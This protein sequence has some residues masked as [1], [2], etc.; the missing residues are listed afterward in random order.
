MS[1]FAREPQVVDPV[2]LTFDERGR[3]YVVEMRDYPLGIGPDHR[4]GGAIRLLEDTDHDGRVDRSTVFAENLSFPTSILACRGGVLVAAPPEIL[5]LQDLDGDG[6][7]D[8]R[9]V[10]LKGF[11]LGVTDSNLSGLR[12]GLDNRVHAVNGGNGGVV[13]SAKSPG[14]PLDLR[15]SDFSFTFD[16]RDLRRTFPTSGGFGLVFDDW[17]HR[18]STYNINHIQQQVLAARYLDAAAG[19]F[20]VEGTA[21]ISDHGDMARIFPVSVAATRVNHPEQAGYFS[22]AGGV[23]FIS[24]PGYRGDLAGSVTVC[25]VVGNLVH[26]DVLSEDGPVFKASRSPGETAREFFASRDPACRPVGL[27]PGPDGALYLIDMQRDVIEHPDYIPQKVKDKLNLR[28]GEDRGRIYRITPKGGLPTPAVDLG[29]LPTSELTKRLGDPRPWWR[30]QAQRLIVERADVRVERRLRDLARHS[31]EPLARL[32]AYWTLAG[33]NRFSQDDLVAILGERHPGLLEN[34]LLLAEEFPSF[35]GE[36]GRLIVRAMDHEHPRVRLQAALTA[37]LLAAWGPETREA[38]ARVWVR[39]F[40]WRWSR[41]AVLAAWRSDAMDLLNRSLASAELASRPPAVL[42]GG[43]RELAMVAAK[44]WGSVDSER[45]KRTLELLAASSL[46][47]SV[48]A[49][50]LNGLAERDPVDAKER[51]ITGGFRGVLL[52]FLQDAD[53]DV[54]RGA[55]ELSARLAVDLGEARKTILATALRIAKDPGQQVP[56]RAAH[57]GLLALAERS[58]MLETLLGLLDVREP[59]EIQRAAWN[60]FKLNGAPDAAAG[61]LSRWRSLT[62]RLRPE[63]IQAL[64]Y[65]KAWQGALLDALERAAI[66]PGELSLDLEQRRQLLR[67]ATPENQKRASRFFSD[68]EYGGRKTLVDDWLARL[69]ES[70]NPENGRAVFSKICAQCHQ[71]GPLGA[72]VGPNLTDQSHRSVEDLVSNILDPNMAVNP[73]FVSVRCETRDGEALV[74]ILDAENAQTVVLRMPPG[75]KQSLPRSQIVRMEFTGTSLMPEGLEAGMTP[76][77]LRDLVAFLQLSPRH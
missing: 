7:A 21:S 13:I 4:P 36:G 41:L 22:S 56:A 43:M 62:P 20:P 25:D 69:P 8:V 40:S 33:L 51:A 15:D 34:G 17:G 60:V 65:R 29:K 57:I 59:F 71:V 46:P 19:L 28:A 70:G 5:F 66:S 32:H 38:L 47:S 23:G 27:E 18:F 75:V 68:E 48:R 31:P 30:R 10:V 67:R 52:P 2:A 39:D 64:C 6:R 44:Q 11:K 72:S 12:W 26:R 45:A 61:L 35:A 9:E 53:P 49:A 1:L 63:L 37:G 73:S 54:I 14:A 3:C 58:T 55:L 76:Q 16:G 24:G 42:A 74:G 77:D 50:V